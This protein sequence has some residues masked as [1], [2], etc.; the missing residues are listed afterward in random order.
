MVIRACNRAYRSTFLHL[1]RA[2][3][4]TLASVLFGLVVALVALIPRAVAQGT[5]ATCLTGFEWMVNSRSQS[6]CLVA[7]YLNSPC[8]SNP[9]NAFV[10]ALPPGSHYAPP[11][12]E[13]ST[14]CR[15]SSVYYSMLQACALCQDDNSV[16]WSTWTANCQNGTFPSVYP[17]DISPGTSVPAWAYLD[18]VQLDN[19]NITAAQ[20]LAAS[21]PPES[22]AGSSATSTTPTSAST[23]RPSPTS[24][25]ANQDSNAS[26]GSGKKTNVGA[27]AGGV[28]AGV[29]G[30]ALIAGA[31]WWFLR[32]R[33]NSRGRMA[34]SSGFDFNG[35][36]VGMHYDEKEQALLSST[37]PHLGTTPLYAPQ[38]VPTPP[39]MSKIYDPNDPS[40]FP[41]ASPEASLSTTAYAQSTAPYG[42]PHNGGYPQ[43]PGRYGGIPEL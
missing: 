26:S 4:Q 15:C 34:P 36:P 35:N 40:T 22:S 31:I 2:R 8:L 30:L 9:S 21:N 3:R 10:L 43:A 1:Q 11:P 7:A 41:S 25:D 33:R 29:V 38:P 27:I 14:P 24:G 32:R 42:Y 28:I 13:N 19:F 6:P 37:T 20:A 17:R 16:P 23:A 12:P 18:V 5:N 39:P